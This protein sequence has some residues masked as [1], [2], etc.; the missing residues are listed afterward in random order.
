MQHYAIS[1]NAILKIQAHR[2]EDETLADIYMSP[3]RWKK[4]LISP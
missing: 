2:H 4:V 3:R 1:R